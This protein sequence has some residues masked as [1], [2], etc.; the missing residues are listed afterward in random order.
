MA[1]TANRFVSEKKRAHVSGVLL[2]AL[3]IFLLIS[4][5][6]H[7]DFD[8]PT[9]SRIRA[10]SFNWGGRI[11]AWFSYAALN[12]VGYA[13]Y[14]LPALG[15][16][17][18]WHRSTGLPLRIALMRSGGLMGLALI[19][20]VAS[21]L[22]HYSRYTAFE[23]GGWFGT[24]I[25]ARLLIPYIGRP[26]SVVLLS[27]LLVA[28]LLVGTDIRRR[29][30]L[31]PFKAL[32]T[33]L[34]TI[35]RWFLR[36]RRR[37]P[38]YAKV[39]TAP[40]TQAAPV[41]ESRQLTEPLPRV[42]R[43]GKNR[44]GEDPVPGQ[45]PVEE[46]APEPV[47]E[48]A[49]EPVPEP[50]SEPV[51]VEPAA[52]SNGDGPQPEG[53]RRSAAAASNGDRA[54]QPPS[55][56]RSGKAPAPQPAKGESAVAAASPPA[57]SAPMVAVESDS[58]SKAGGAYRIPSIDLLDPTPRE[59]GGMERDQFLENAKLLEEAMG[60]FDVT[61]K[62][63]QVSPGP[64]VTR[65]EVEPAPGV[66]VNRI[67][68]LSDDL[69]RVMSAKG[70]RIQAPVPGRSVVG[71][72]I[73]NQK[74]E[75]V[76]LREIVE[77]E[78]FRNCTATLP[79][80]LGKTISGEPL[81]ADLARMPHLLV[82]GATGSGKSVCI[83]SLV[84]SILFK[85]TPDQVRLL[86]VDPK[87]VELT[88][89]NDIPHLLVP[90]VTEP[91]KASEA[92]KW[93]VA[94]MESRYQLLAKLS[95]RHLADYNRKVE[96]LADDEV[97]PD[98]RPRPLP[99]IVVVV[100]EFADLM[101]TAPADVETSLMSLAQKSRAVGIHII[102]ATQRP[103]VNVIT[104]V[105]K[106]NFPSRIGFQVASKT[107]SRTI[108]DMNGAERL[109]GR[110]D[111]LYLPGGQGEPIRIH[112]AFISGEETERLVA[113]I[114]SCQYEAEE[115]EIFFGRSDF[116][117]EA[118]ERDELFD[119]AVRTVI[120]HQQAS[121]SFL[122]RRMKIG[123]SRAARLMDELEAAGM[124]GPASGARPRQILVEDQ[125]PSLAEAAAALDEEEEAAG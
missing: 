93:A 69:A 118:D 61:G 48:S 75:T 44:A 4:L 77:S 51:V 79:M 13:A 6:T 36:P 62:V 74:Q 122:Q 112:G 34:K 66:K 94:E 59:R 23:I 64:V 89:Y 81:I 30:C 43:Q 12:A 40:G 117:A 10:E 110:G 120:V 5:A 90:V 104:G 82:A 58:P 95:V 7:S 113:S 45:A 108:L 119:E 55:G 25:S 102:L 21:G 125:G 49:V 18:G 80:A 97:A 124:V 98:D 3:G 76:Y 8:A 70:I 114:Q 68:T 56:K 107:D 42:T 20:S 11:G 67:V 27:A 78:E 123:Y 60:D 9:S 26:G 85:A 105:I 37:P 19:A 33:A 121:T 111:M 100:D 52:S 29:H 39:E 116:E 103:S 109:L 47:G 73:A 88:V 28:S 87:V 99:Y 53:R 35:G 24:E 46:R 92:L 63:T 41:P 31:A 91:K 17:W 83:N 72:E 16:L 71:V 32:G 54:A 22:P 2:A 1:T 15:L 50:P 106:A 57:R 86:M 101:I 96:N 84:S 38:P 115:V 14:V 65:Y